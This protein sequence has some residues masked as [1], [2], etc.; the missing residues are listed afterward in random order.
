MA[1]VTKIIQRKF[2]IQNEKFGN[3]GK[4]LDKKRIETLKMLKSEEKNE[5]ESFLNTTSKW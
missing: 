1:Q 4:I 2:W 3:M 5:R